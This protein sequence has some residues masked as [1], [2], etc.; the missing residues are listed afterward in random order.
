MIPIDDES[1]GRNTGGGSG[2][3]STKHGKA[4]GSRKWIIPAIMAVVA[5]VLAFTF[6]G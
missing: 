4:G 3:G 2:G 1:N 5:I 6:L